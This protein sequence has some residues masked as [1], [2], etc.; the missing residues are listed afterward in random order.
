MSE[1]HKLHV[2]NDRTNEN[3]NGHFQEVGWVY[4]ISM[5]EISSETKYCICYLFN[6]VYL[7]M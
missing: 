6:F 1:P 2:S 4:F 7:M 3:T 5:F